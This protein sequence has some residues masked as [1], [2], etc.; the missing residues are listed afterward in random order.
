MISIMLLSL[1]PSFAERGNK[2]GNRFRLQLIARSIDDQPRCGFSDHFNYSEA[3]LAQRSSSLHQVHDAIG[4]TQQR[5][6]FHRA[7]QPDD[8]DR[9]AARAE[10]LRGYAGVSCCDSKSPVAAQA[11]QVAQWKIP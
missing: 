3:V 1:A 7:G 6:H 4:E 2:T 5:R 9:Q 8:L 11:T 10:V